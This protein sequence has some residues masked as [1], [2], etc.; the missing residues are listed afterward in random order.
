MKSKFRVAGISLVVGAVHLCLAAGLWAHSATV[1][2]AA[3]DG[4]NRSASI[5]GISAA[6]I[7]R[8]RSRLR[9][10]AHNVDPVKPKAGPDKHRS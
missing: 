1:P 5:W 8:S 10:S 2:P 7:P 3:S 9:P 4:S 6:V